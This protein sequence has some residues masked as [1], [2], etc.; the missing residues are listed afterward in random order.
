M[1]IAAPLLAARL[2]RVAPKRV[3]RI[4][5]FGAIGPSL[6]EMVVVWGWCAPGLHAAAALNPFYV[7]F[8][9]SSF[10]LSGIAVLLAFMRI[11]MLGFI[12]AISPVPF[13]DP[14][15]CSGVF[16]LAPLGDQ[17]LAGCGWHWVEG[18]LT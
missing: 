9:Q 3:P 1:I 5:P 18:G 6:L 12:L 17:R 4:A 16:R 13:Y 14:A 15:L 8:Q 2:A 7:A 11:S 10:L